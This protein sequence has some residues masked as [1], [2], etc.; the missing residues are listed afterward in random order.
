VRRGRLVDCGDD[1]DIDARRQHGDRRRAAAG[2]EARAL[3]LAVM[4]RWGAMLMRNYVRHVV[5]R[6]CGDA[7]VTVLG[8]R[9]EGARIEE[10][11]LE[12]DG[13]NSR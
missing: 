1:L 5:G 2:A 3:V 8:A 6:L 4:A 12:P 11:N 10:G 9:V 13:P 7:M